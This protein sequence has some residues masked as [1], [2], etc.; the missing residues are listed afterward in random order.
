MKPSGFNSLDQALATAQTQKEAAEKQRPPIFLVVGLDFGTAYTKCMVRDRNYRKAYPVPYTMKGGKTYFLPSEIYFGQGRMSHPLQDSREE[1]RTLAFLKMALAAA[2]N[3]S[4]SDWLDGVTKTINAEQNPD[5]LRSVKSLVIFFLVHT[6]KHVHSFIMERWKNFGQIKGDTVFY[7]MAVP[8]AH[9]RDEAIMATF[10]EC[11]EVAVHY[12]QSGIEIPD[13]L[14]ELNSLAGKTASPTLD[15][16]DLLP[17]V[18]ANIQSYVRSRGGREGL[19]LFADVGAGT[20]DYSVFLFYRQDGE[21]LLSYPH[22]AVEHLGSSQLELRTYQRCHLDLT[23]QIR[24]LKESEISEGA[25]TLDLA[26]ELK[27]TQK[28]LAT[29]ITDATTKVI[30]LTRRKIRRN[31]FQ[32]MQILYG[33]G[34]CAPNPYQSSIAASFTPGWGLIAESQPLPEPPDVEWPNGDGNGLFR[35]FSVAYGLSFLPTDF[36]LQ[37]FPD[38]IDELDPDDRPRKEL[39]AAPTKDEV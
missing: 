30:G 22:A 6:L 36:P 28:S 19:Y 38:E 34:G 25:Y 31:Q 13:S 17:E 24:L 33:G 16:C 20:V 32:R 8:V 10:R 2:A 29:E 27:A 5:Q 14:E 37:R 23:R 7:N 11:L 1:T 12:L 35:R 18:T 15:I 26:K 3:G 4:R 39:P 9:A 21:L